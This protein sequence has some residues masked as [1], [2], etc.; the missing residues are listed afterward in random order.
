MNKKLVF[1]LKKN[2]NIYL[3]KNENLS[4]LKKDI[5]EL[6]KYIDKDKHHII[7]RNFEKKATCALDFFVVA[8]CQYSNFAFDTGGAITKTNIQSLLLQHS[9]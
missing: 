1:N 2:L 3:N 9:E 7:I 6:K 8:P 5:L 4:D